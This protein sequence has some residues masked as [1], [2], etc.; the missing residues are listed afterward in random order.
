MGLLRGKE[1]EFRTLHSVAKGLRATRIV[2]C[3]KHALLSDPYRRR[4]G[5]SPQSKGG[6]FAS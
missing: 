6:S 2:A 3:L 4:P 5:S 1:L